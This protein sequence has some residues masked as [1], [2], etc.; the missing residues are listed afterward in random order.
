MKIN[1]RINKLLMKMESYSLAFETQEAVD[2]IRKN[3]D[4]LKSDLR[5]VWLKN[6]PEIVKEIDEQLRKYF[7]IPANRKLVFSFYEVKKETLKI[8]SERDN[9][10]N[11]I[12]IPTLDDEMKTNKGKVYDL[13]SWEA[14]LMPSNFKLSTDIYF[15]AKIK[16]KIKRENLRRRIVNNNERFVLVFEYNFNKNELNDFFNIDNQEDKIEI[17]ESVDCFLNS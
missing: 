15:P 5:K 4:F 10:V 2:S 1:N 12:V 9:I 16:N 11:R 13:N 3:N 6:Y 8:H 17:D 14:Y 7:Q